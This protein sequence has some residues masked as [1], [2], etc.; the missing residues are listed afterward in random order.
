MPPKSSSTKSQ[1]RSRLKPNPTPK[2]TS[3][4]TPHFVVVDTSFPSH[5]FTDRSLFTTYT[6]L[7]KVHQTP[8]GSNVT[9][10]GVGEVKV[11]VTVKGEPIAFRFLDCWH[12]PSSPHHFLSSQAVTSHGNQVMIAG[13]TPRMILVHKARLLN[14]KLPKYMP[15]TRVDGLFVLK[16][17]RISVP[18]SIPPVSPIT[19]TTVPHTKQTTPPTQTAVPVPHPKR[20]SPPVVSLHAS[21]ESS[22][23]FVALSFHPH[24]HTSHLSQSSSPPLPPT[25]QPPPNVNGNGY[26]DIQ[27]PSSRTLPTNP[28][29][30][31]SSLNKTS[32]R[33]TQEEEERICERVAQLLMERMKGEDLAKAVKRLDHV[34]E[35]GRPTIAA[36]PP[37][38]AMP[39]PSIPSFGFGYGMC[40]NPGST[41]P[42]AYARR[43]SSVPLP[44]G[45]STF[46]FPS[47]L[48]SHF[49]CIKDPP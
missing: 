9:I 33:L 13:R 16:F 27:T 7:R 8:F 35:E 28:A 17:T 45:S 24:P 4:S 15:F 42:P 34:K 23:P 10:E 39:T 5:I 40:S 20:S 22:P 18:A 41:F 19:Q 14:P 32:D 49:P 47:A 21:S 6:P 46:F 37:N 48:S 26:N 12:V 31:L 44:N 30:N 43:S 2:N 11:C 38:L 25:H 29:T 1:P 36:V 3:S